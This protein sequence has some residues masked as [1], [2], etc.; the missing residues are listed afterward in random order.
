MDLVVSTPGRLID[1]LNKQF[2][3]LDTVSTLIIDEFDK[4][5]DPSFWPQINF[6]NSLLPNSNFCQKTLFS[7]SFAPQ[8]RSFVCE[9]FNPFNLEPAFEAVKQAEQIAFETLQNSQPQDSTS[10]KEEYCELISGYDLLVIGGL[11]KVKQVVKEE[12]VVV[13]NDSQKFAWLKDKIK[14]LV[15]KGK[16]LIFVNSKSRAVQIQKSLRKSLLLEIPCI[17]GDLFTFQRHQILQDFR[18]DSDVL[19]STDVLGRGIDIQDI[20]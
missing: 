5:L 17:Y 6:I 20:Q 14:E 8:V 10:E 16:V 18:N 1:L 3:T 13:Q 4:M 11:N 7:A 19:I 12:F 2:L 9:I 15:L